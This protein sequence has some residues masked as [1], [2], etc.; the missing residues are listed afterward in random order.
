MEL[1]MLVV[2]VA[3]AVLSL[4]AAEDG[5]GAAVA[6]ADDAGSAGATAAPV[7]S[8]LAAIEAARVAHGLAPSTPVASPSPAKPVEGEPK[9]AEQAKPGALDLDPRLAQAAKRCHL[10]EEDL[11]ALAEKRGKTA[12]EA[13][14][15]KQAD[16]LDGMAKVGGEVGR[17]AAKPGE[18]PTDEGATTD[19]AAPYVFPQALRETYPDNGDL[20]DAVE[21]HFRTFNTAVQG[22]MDAI[23]GLVVRGTADR[24]LS[25]AGPSA[26]GVTRDA[27]LDKAELL[28]KGYAVA[29]KDVDYEEVLNEALKGLTQPNAAVAARAD[30]A[31]KVTARSTQVQGPPAGRK[32]PP[33]TT[34]EAK[35][36]DGI[37]QVEVFRLAHGLPPS[38]PSS[39]R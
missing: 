25:T 11:A 27:F 28:A 21:G 20:F 8:G 16:M 32:P 13:M 35:R 39:R 14:L 9:P 37:D 5:G 19:E 15:T 36:A 38:P 18:K 12:L 31:T 2:I 3:L 6:V 17:T 10:D 7:D 26:E 23:L 29:G 1:V 22:R 33:P 24:L 34:K 4:Y 30:L